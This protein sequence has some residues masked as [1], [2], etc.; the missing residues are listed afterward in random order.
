M[1]HCHAAGRQG[2][3]RRHYDLVAVGACRGIVELAVRPLHLK[4]LEVVAGAQGL[5]HGYHHG[6]IYTPCGDGF[7]RE[8]VLLAEHRILKREHTT[9]RHLPLTQRMYVR[10]LSKVYR[11]GEGCVR[12]GIGRETLLLTQGRPSALLRA[13][14]GLHVVGQLHHAEG[15]IGTLP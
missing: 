1:A 13:V 12:V 11:H 15:H 2:L 8:L 14:R 7:G 9:L 6:A 3:P 4:L 10:R 5:V